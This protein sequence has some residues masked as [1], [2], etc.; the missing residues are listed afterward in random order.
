MAPPVVYFLLAGT[1]LPGDTRR[2]LDQHPQTNRRLLPISRHRDHHL[3]ELPAAPLE[4]R[5]PGA[6]TKQ[7]SEELR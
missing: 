4:P 3:A 7:D 6:A 1:A 5:G 2:E